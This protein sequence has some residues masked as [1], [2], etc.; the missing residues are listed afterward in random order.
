MVRIT[1]HISLGDMTLAEISGSHIGL[2]AWSFEA[3][4][5]LFPPTSSDIG[6]ARIAIIMPRSYCQEPNVNL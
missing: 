3:V 1:C 6:M 5:G 2:L 4:Q